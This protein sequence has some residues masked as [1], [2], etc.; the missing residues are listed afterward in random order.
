MVTH[1]QFGTS[2]S[3]NG[4]GYTFKDPALV[5][6]FLTVVCWS[7]NRLFRYCLLNMWIKISNS[8]QFTSVKVRSWTERESSNLELNMPDRPDPSVIVAGNSYTR[9]VACIGIWPGNFLRL[10]VFDIPPKPYYRGV[11]LLSGGWIHLSRY[12]AINHHT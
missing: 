4:N 11:I 7:F 12:P 2:G 3:G 5:P 9:L 10:Y 8:Y 6:V 1:S